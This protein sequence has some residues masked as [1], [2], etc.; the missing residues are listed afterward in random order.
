MGK[1]RQKRQLCAAE[2]AYRI[3][4]VADAVRIQIDHILRVGKHPEL[5]CRLN[6]DIAPP[7]HGLFSVILIK[8]TDMGVDGFRPVRQMKIDLNKETLH[9]LK[10]IHSQKF[11]PVRSRDAGKEHRAAAV[12]HMPVLTAVPL[13]PPEN[14]A[15]R[16]PR[17]AG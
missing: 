2:Y 1:G 9:P 4:I 11:F 3:H 12:D 10:L 13:H 6:R 7:V 15:L 17:F 16:I 14:Q 5:L 8:N